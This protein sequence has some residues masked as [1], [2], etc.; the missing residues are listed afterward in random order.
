MQAT[1]NRAPRRL[2]FALGVILT[3]SVMSALLLPATVD[4][5]PAT[6]DAKPAPVDAKPAAARPPARKIV[7]KRR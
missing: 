5:K 4:A 7:R 2:G 3:G 1:G 6:V